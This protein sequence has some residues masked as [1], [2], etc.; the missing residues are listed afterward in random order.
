M[1]TIS[2]KKLMEVAIKN[3][4]KQGYTIIKESREFT[5]LP[6]EEFIKDHLNNYSER[7]AIRNG[8][9]PSVINKCIKNIQQDKEL[10]VLGKDAYKFTFKDGVSAADKMSFVFNI[11]G[12]ELLDVS[13]NHIVILFEY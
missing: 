11:Q 13:D 1:K 3:A 12:D 5:D 10:D 7:A 6:I 8:S 4:K 2:K 9:F